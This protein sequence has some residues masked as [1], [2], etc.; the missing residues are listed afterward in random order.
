MSHQSSHQ[1]GGGRGGAPRSYQQNQ[2]TDYSRM[3]Q[4]YDNQNCLKREVFVDW[5]R[6]LAQNLGVTRTNLR[7][8]F[9]FI[10]ALHFRIK[11][12]ET[13]ESVL[14]EGIPQLHRFAQYQ[15][16]RKVITDET[17]GFLQAHCDAV[18]YDQ[19]KFEG[20]YQLFQSVIAYLGR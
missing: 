3:T 16:G 10:S 13:P 15:A 5:P 7:R 17:K 12:G 9:D 4:Y 8:A 19:R 20:F 2:S 1:P 6:Q 11:M 18:G 14:K